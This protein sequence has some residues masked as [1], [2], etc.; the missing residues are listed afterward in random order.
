[1]TFSALCDDEHGP[2][3]GLL[4]ALTLV[5]GL[6]DAVAFLALGRA[7]VGNMTGNVVF[8]GLAVG[9]I[10]GFSVL[11]PLLSVTAFSA[12]A[13][14]GGRVAA[15]FGAHR[16]RHIAVALAIEAALMGAAIA[17]AVPAGPA[18]AHVQLALLALAMGMQAATARRL[19]VPDLTTTVLTQ[20][21]TGL[22]SESVLAGGAG[23]NQL[24]RIAALVAL[25]CGAALGAA[26]MLW[27]S[28]P[29]ALGVALAVIVAALAWAYRAARA[30]A[31][32][33]VAR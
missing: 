23:P 9:G 3:P 25:A 12:G 19:A 4:L 6:V 24:R 22:A 17:L 2:L 33:A 11:P 1:M 16:G 32:W 8:A 27:T 18:L 26:M 14:A 7:F 20:T 30:Q 31:P 21:L 29:L 15:R 28:L 13:I 10:S 5:T